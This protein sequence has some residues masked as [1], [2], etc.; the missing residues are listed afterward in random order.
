MEGRLLL[1]ANVEWGLRRWL[2][3]SQSMPCSIV[4]SKRLIKIE[5]ALEIVGDGRLIVTTHIKAQILSE[6]LDILFAQRSSDLSITSNLLLLTRSVRGVSSDL[7]GLIPVYG[8]SVCSSLRS[9]VHLYSF[10]LKALFLGTG[11]RRRVLLVAMTRLII[12]RIL[13]NISLTT[14]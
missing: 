5:A 7:Q 6:E 2:Q 11:Q 9:S 4:N 10:P 3:C 1:L 12:P 14:L 13:G 8:C